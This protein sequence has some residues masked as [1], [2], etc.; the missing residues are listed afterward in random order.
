MRIVITFKMGYGFPV[1]FYFTVRSNLI[2]CIFL[3]VTPVRFFIDW[4]SMSHG[5]L[6]WRHYR[7]LMIYPIAYLCAASI[8]GLIT[9]ALIVLLDRKLSKIL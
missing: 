5:K 6:Q 2:V 3:S 8:E 9:G 4:L 1:F 7:L